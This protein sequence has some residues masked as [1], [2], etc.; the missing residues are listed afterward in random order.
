MSDRS[1]T[2]G[3]QGGQLF[4]NMDEQEQ[5]YAPNQL[6]D[7]VM[8]AH[9]VDR[10]DTAASNTA[11]GN[12][13]DIDT[14]PVAVG[15]GTGGSASAAAPASDEFDPGMEREEHDLRR[16]DTSVVGPDP[17]DEQIDP[18]RTR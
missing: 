11:Q 4:K 16:G 14:T 1:E 15:L 8:P 13:G 17:R 7:A 6:P 3:G 9:E 5:I 2:T 18:R 12:A 10:G